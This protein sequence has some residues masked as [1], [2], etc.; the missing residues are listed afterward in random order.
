MDPWDAS[1][2]DFAARLGRQGARRAPLAARTQTAYLKD[3]RALAGWIAEHGIAGPERITPSV[4]AAALRALGWSPATQARALTATREW[5]SPLF[6]PGRSPAERLERPRV[7]APLIPR[8]SQRDATEL[9]ESVDLGRPHT[10]VL[11]FALA[12]R[13]RAILELLYGSALRRQEVCDL[14]LAGLDFE[15]ETVRVVGKGDKARTIPLT[16]PAVEAL[17]EWLRDGRPRLVD[18]TGP[19]RSEVFVSQRGRPLDG[20]A[21]YRVV[22]PRLRAMGRAGGPHLLRHA[23]ATHLLEGHHDG[24][25]AHLRVVQEVLGHASLATTQ[26]YTGVTTKDIQRQLKRGHPRG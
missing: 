1:L 21:V 2:T 23:A 13:N 24:E 26:R 5:L 18:A 25:G 20:S 11:H 15:H 16:E 19:A 22:A 10:S 14:T 7:R 9:V 4:L 3:V 17:G 12:L 8:L 6:P